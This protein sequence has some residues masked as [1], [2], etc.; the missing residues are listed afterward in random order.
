[1]SK[2]KPFQQ[3]NNLLA[4]LSSAEYKRISNDLE[5]VKVYGSEVLYDS[6]ENPHSVIFPIDCLILL[7]YETE[8]DS[9]TGAIVGKEGAVG[10]NMILSNQVM[11]YSAIVQALGQVY[12]LP[13]APFMDEFNRRESLYQNLLSYMT[14]LPTQT[15]QK[16]AYSHPYKIDEQPGSSLLK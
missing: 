3:Y 8:T 5:L 13:M 14:I 15:A 10:A 7:H 12:Q 16:A 6:G 4:S 9:K 11:P 1:M 2:N